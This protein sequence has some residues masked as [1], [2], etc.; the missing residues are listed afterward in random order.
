MKMKKISVTLGE[1]GDENMLPAAT[2]TV[3]MKGRAEN[4]TH[5]K[6]KHAMTLESLARRVAPW[7]QY[8]AQARF[9]ADQAKGTQEGNTFVKLQCTMCIIALQR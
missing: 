7:A 6:D 1:G 3:T 4:T 2:Y 8:I 9:T 5:K